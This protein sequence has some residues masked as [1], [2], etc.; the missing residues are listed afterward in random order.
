MTTETLVPPLPAAAPGS[1]ITWRRFRD[2][3]ADLPGMAAANQRMR[4]RTGMLEPITTESMRHGYTHLVNSDPRTD[5]IIVEL[6]GVTAGYAR[7]E[8]HDL[9]D[10]D[11][12]YELTTVVEPAAWGLGVADAMLEW[13]EARLRAIA[14]DNPSDR[15]SWFGNYAFGDNAEVADALVR[16][17]YVAVRWDAEMLRPDLDDISDAAVPEG[18]ELRTPEPDELPLVH[19]MA[20][21][22]FAEH[23]GEWDA[24][25][26]SYAEWVED[27]DF[28]RDLVVVAFAPDG[29]P[30]AYVG[31]VLEA[32]PD[33]TIR[34]LLDSV[35][36]HPDHRRRGLAR[37][38]ILESLRRL[39]DAGASSAYLGVDTDNHNRAL[40]LYESCG[41][42][43]ASSATNYRKPFTPEDPA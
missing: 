27:P 43:K 16:R 40:A 10:G 36:T 37:A 42:R 34:G 38:A 35:A 32:M 31:N 9:T 20:V 8:W 13:G 23:W 25:E 22:A 11:R 41:F 19:D 1:G 2:L 33:G 6:D 14:R 30:A 17:G 18:Y 21:A 29:R 26:Q 15:R 4:D 12:V 7:A 39:R 3:D 28:R 24:D 5:C